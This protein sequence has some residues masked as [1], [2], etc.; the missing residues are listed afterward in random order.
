M[1]TK[2]M[3]T[4]TMKTKSLLS[5]TCA[6]VLLC[7]DGQANAA[8][9]VTNGN[10]SDLTGLTYVGGP[11]YS[12]VP[13]GWSG[14]NTGY[15]VIYTGNPSPGVYTYAANLLSLA[16]LSPF[17]SLNQNVGT[18]DVA[19]DVTL[20]FDLTSISAGSTFDVGAAI[21]NATTGGLLATAAQLHTGTSELTALNVA[22]GTL[23][24]IAL[25]YSY[26]PTAP[27]L[28]NVSISQIPEPSTGSMM[29][30]GLAGLVTTRLLRRKSS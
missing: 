16:S 19:G 10:F 26:A 8:L 3:K 17:V 29:A 12:G 13:T 30:L 27:G 4:K 1:K 14:A 7:L 11:W 21:F 24:N 5:L 18:T 2:T 15:S 28:T 6:L 20:K 23:L 9:V 25:W 22:S